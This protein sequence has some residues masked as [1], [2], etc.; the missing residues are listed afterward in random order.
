MPEAVNCLSQAALTELAGLLMATS[1]FE[2]LMQAVADLAG[3]AV[4]AAATCGITLSEDGHLITV[5]SADALARLLDEQQYELLDGPCLEAIRTARMV[6]SDDLSIDK[7]WDGYP[8]MAVAH[9][10][11]T[12]L[13]SPLMVGSSPIGALNLYATAA[14]AFTPDARAAAGQLTALAAATMTAAMRHYDQTTLT[15]HLRT[16]LSSRSVIDQAIG[17]IIG[18]QRCPPETA[19]DILRTVSQNR[20]IPLRE[21]AADLVARTIAPPGP[22]VAG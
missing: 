16:A 7:R 5:A 22:P 9:G 20:N 4:P 14:G 18:S 2:D 19:F 8:A 17:I 3:R 13:S 11:R 15:D 10:V 21:V 1:S 6:L 12:V